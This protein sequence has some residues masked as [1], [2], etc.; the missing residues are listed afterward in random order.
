MAKN[1]TTQALGEPA[2]QQQRW[3]DSIVLDTIAAAP[4]VNIFAPP[5]GCVVQVEAW[6][7]TIVT[8]ITTAAGA[9]AVFGLAGD[10]DGAGYVDIHQVDVEAVAGGTLTA[11]TVWEFNSD[12]CFVNGVQVNAV[13]VLP[14]FFVDANVSGYCNFDV[15]VAGAGAGAAGTVRPFIRHRFLV[16]PEQDFNESGYF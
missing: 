4:S 3:D 10:P 13:N 15:S 2:G 12:G 8:A 1:E 7:F 5:P 16:A 6:G 11:G 9:N 14:V